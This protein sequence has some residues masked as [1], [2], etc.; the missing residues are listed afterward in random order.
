VLLFL[1]T[2]LEQLDLALEHIL[3]RDIH[4]ARF[5]L[6]LTDNALELVLHQIAKDKVND[7]KSYAWRREIY[8]H[9][10]ALDKALGRSFGDKVNFARLTGPVT[11]EMAKTLGIMHGFRNEVYHVGLQHEAILPALSWFYFDVTCEY[12]GGYR[13]RY[14]GWGS[15]QKIPDRAKKYLTGHH[16][17]PGEREDFANGCVAMAQACG[18]NP[19]ETVAAL[20]DHMDDVIEEQDNCIGVI[21]E[22]VYAHQRTTRATRRLPA[23]RL[24]LSRFRRKARLSAGNTGSRVTRTSSSTGSESIIS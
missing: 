1:A 15:N 9:R 17:F 13:P 4:N 7:L 22:G 8:I 3:K 10:A 18:H 16:T 20:A 21:A 24:G 11:E 19:A 6:M 2:V 12:L 14:L 5:G 23:A